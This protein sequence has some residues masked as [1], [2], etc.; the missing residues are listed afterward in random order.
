[1]QNLTPIQIV[2]LSTS[3]I[4]SISSPLAGMQVYDTDIGVIKTYIGTSWVNYDKIKAGL[5][6]FMPG[7]VEVDT[8]I[9]YL[10]FDVET[11]FPIGVPNS[12]VSL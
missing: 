1:M 7:V 10:I 5:L 11:T 4:N 6:G 8:K 9:L 3:E 12:V 2:Q